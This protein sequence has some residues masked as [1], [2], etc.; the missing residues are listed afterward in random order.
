MYQESRTSSVLRPPRRQV[1]LVLLWQ[2]FLQARR[3]AVQAQ[4]TRRLHDMRS[5]G[6]QITK[7]RTPVDRG[8]DRIQ[9]I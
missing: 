8:K 6:E 7:A 1:M 2:T 3:P 4:L 5:K 9:H